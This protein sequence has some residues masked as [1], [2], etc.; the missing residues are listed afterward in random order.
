VQLNYLHLQECIENDILNA[1]VAKQPVLLCIDSELGLLQQN[2][3]DSDEPE[4]LPKR[5]WCFRLIFY[6]YELDLA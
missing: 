5:G 2:S 4:H 3:E 1:T 6:A